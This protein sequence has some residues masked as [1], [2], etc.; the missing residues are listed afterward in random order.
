MP[1]VA[2]LLLMALLPAI[3]EE[4]MFRG[5]LYTAFL[6]KM[7]FL[8]AMICVSLLFGISHMSLIKLIPTALLGCALFYARERSQSMAASSLIHFLNNGFSIFILYYGDRIP[9]FRDESMGKPMVILLIV[10]ALVCI[11]VGGLL[12]GRGKKK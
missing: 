12:F 8:P 2:G 9:V 3:C 4:L 7:Q 11:P 5:Y 6:E 10:L 1:F